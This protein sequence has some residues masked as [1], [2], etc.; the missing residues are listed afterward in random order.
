M[1]TTKEFSAMI[2]EMFNPVIDDGDGFYQL[3]AEQVG[4]KSL[5]LHE[6]EVA[7]AAGQKAI[8]S[9]EL[10]GATVPDCGRGLVWQVAWLI[11]Q[12]RLMGK[13]QAA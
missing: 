6:R 1:Q 7:F 11:T 5:T 2:E 3:V 4:Q 13:E 9:F 10:Y 8:E 12:R